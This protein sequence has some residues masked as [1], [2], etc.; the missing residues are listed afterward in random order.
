MLILLCFSKIIGFDNENKLVLPDYFQLTDFN[1]HCLSSNFKALQILSA[2]PPLMI[3]FCCFKNFHVLPWIYR[4][5]GL[6]EEKISMFYFFFCVIRD[7]SSMI[8]HDLVWMTQRWGLVKLWMALDLDRQDQQL[9]CDCIFW[10]NDAPYA[11]T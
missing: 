9:E 4:S 1:D 11:C 8:Y 7:W 3:F 6:F 5:W 2:W 10:Q